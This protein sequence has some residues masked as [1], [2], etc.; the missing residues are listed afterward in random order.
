MIY[1]ELFIWRRNHY[2]S[3]KRDSFLLI[4]AIAGR[5]R[6]HS[7][8][9]KLLVHF[10]RTGKAIFGDALPVLCRRNAFATSLS[11][12]EAVTAVSRPILRVPLMHLDLLARFETTIL[13]IPDYAYYNASVRHMA[14]RINFMTALRYFGLGVAEYTRP[15]GLTFGRTRI[16][17]WSSNFKTSLQALLLSIPKGCR[18]A[19]LTDGLTGL[20][21]QA[22]TTNVSAVQFARSVAVNGHWRGLVFKAKLDS[23]EAK[24]FIACYG[25]VVSREMRGTLATTCGK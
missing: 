19:F 2:G 8:A 25:I 17:D 4:F 9:V 14:H 24:W 6:H 12:M 1:E 7:E 15:Y 22:S 23:L 16:C 20:S 21:S 13:V 10:L 5:T 18:V 11:V 3:P